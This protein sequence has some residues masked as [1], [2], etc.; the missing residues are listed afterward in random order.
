[1]NVSLKTGH[2]STQSCFQ[3]CPVATSRIAAKNLTTL[4]CMTKTQTAK[5]CHAGEKTFSPLATVGKEASVN[6]LTGLQTE[7]GQWCKLS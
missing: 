2:E 6:L 4:T 5:N 1:M 7:K 3:F